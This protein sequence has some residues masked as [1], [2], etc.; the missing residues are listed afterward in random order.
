MGPYGYYDPDVSFFLGMNVLNGAVGWGILIY[1]VLVYLSLTIWK[2]HINRLHRMGF[3]ARL[4]GLAFVLPVFTA[5]LA[6]LVTI[7]T[8]NLAGGPEGEVLGVVVSLIGGGGSALSLLASG[9]LFLL[10][11]LPAREMGAQERPFGIPPVPSL[12]S[13]AATTAQPVKEPWED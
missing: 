5:L 2:S 11:I 10:S 3:A 4:L 8:N 9:I 12:K 1:A 13:S 7:V 6:L